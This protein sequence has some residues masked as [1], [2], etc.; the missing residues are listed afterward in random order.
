M[1]AAKSSS[2]DEHI[3]APAQLKRVKTSVTANF[4]WIIADFIAFVESKI[5]N[6]EI[7]KEGTALKTITSPPFSVRCGETEIHFELYVEIRKGADDVGFYLRNCNHKDVK[8]MCSLNAINKAGYEFSEVNTGHFR[9]TQKCK[10]KGIAKF[11]SLK[12]LKETSNDRLPN[13]SLKLGCDLTV[14]D[15][16]VFVDGQ[17]GEKLYM[18][19]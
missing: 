18:L 4:E 1:S 12:N 8:V 14:Y 2:D 17:E 7:S 15:N 10:S 5:Q 9:F 16:E 3:V 6:L 11:I 13:G 19:A